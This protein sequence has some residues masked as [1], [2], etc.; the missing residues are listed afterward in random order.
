MG[1][2]MMNRMS[3]RIGGGGMGINGGGQGAMN[4]MMGGESEFRMNPSVWEEF[5]GENG[6]RPRYPNEVFGRG[7][8][9]AGSSFG[10]GG[11]NAC[12]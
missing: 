4:P 3:D 11:S 9:S 10:R 1:M 12:D 7:G 6:K 2:N 8:G 5:P